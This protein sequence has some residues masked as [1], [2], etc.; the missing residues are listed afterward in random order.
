MCSLALTLPVLDVAAMAW[1]FSSRGL[2]VFHEERVLV[3]GPSRS[4]VLGS[5]CIGFARCTVRAVVRY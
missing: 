5:T 2:H 3:S 4:A 1:E